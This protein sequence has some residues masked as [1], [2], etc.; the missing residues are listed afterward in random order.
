MKAAMLSLAL[1]RRFALTMR[2]RMRA[3]TGSDGFAGGLGSL[4]PI[5]HRAQAG[6]VSMDTQGPKGI[7]SGLG[8]DFCAVP[9]KEPPGLGGRQVFE[10]GK[11]LACRMGG[12]EQAL[13]GHTLLERL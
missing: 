12:R 3:E 9:G 7:T 4:I 1:K 6:H 11:K 2:A 8:A 5:L 13:G 10:N